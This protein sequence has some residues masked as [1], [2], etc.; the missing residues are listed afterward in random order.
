MGK[1]AA[2]SIRV[3]ILREGIEESSLCLS[4]N[5]TRFANKRQKGIYRNHKPENVL[6]EQEMQ[7]ENI[8]GEV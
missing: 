6:R 4:T 2:E 1:I 3:S 7:S 8:C 5:N